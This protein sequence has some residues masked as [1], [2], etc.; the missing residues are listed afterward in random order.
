MFGLLS[1]I[2]FGEEPELV[3]PIFGLSSL[4]PKLM[5]ADSYLL[6]GRL[7]FLN[8]NSH[9]DLPLE[10]TPINP[11]REGLFRRHPERSRRHQAQVAGHPQGTGQLLGNP[12]TTAKRVPPRS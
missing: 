2:L 7:P 9:H 3:I 11:L 1:Q 5:R 10:L 4:L 8:F 12:Q 6:F